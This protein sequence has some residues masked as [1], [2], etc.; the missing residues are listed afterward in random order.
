TLVAMSGELVVP[1]TSPLK[2]AK[3][4]VTA[5]ADRGTIYDKGESFG[6][7]P[8]LQAY[9]GSVWFAAA[10]F[11]LNVAVAHGRG[12]PSPVRVHVGGNITFWTERGLGAGEWGLGTGDYA[13]PPVP[14]PLTLLLSPDDHP[15]DDL[16]H[17]IDLLRLLDR[18]GAAGFARHRARQRHHMILD[19]DADV[20]ALQDVLIEELRMDARLDEGV[21]DRLA[22]PGHALRRL[23]GGLGT[24]V[25]PLHPRGL[26][27]FPRL[28]P[29]GLAGVRRLVDGLVD[30]ALRLLAGLVDLAVGLAAG[31]GRVDVDQ[32]LI[33]D[34]RDA[35]DLGEVR[36]L[37]PIG[38]RRHGAGERRD[39]VVQRHFD[40]VFLQRRV[41]D[42]LLDPLS[43]R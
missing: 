3:F 18:A 38:L 7:R 29:R 9:G 2:I 14:S 5:F 1:L 43:E 16:V 21:G 17:A 42:P 20:A 25:L 34:P 22:R 33:V 30:A 4:G 39:A 40:V 6:D 8:M 23:V 41:V 32:Q 27:P 19:V 24:D 31:A 15:V 35:G 36:R 26:A 10:L 37:A 13:S 12:A 28:P 11:R